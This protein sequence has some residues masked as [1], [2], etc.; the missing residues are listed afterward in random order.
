LGHVRRRHPARSTLRSPEI[1]QNRNFALAND[2]VKFLFVDFDRL[3][4]SR[5]F[6]LAGTA[7]AN[8]GKV[9]GGNAIWLAARGTVANDRHGSILGHDSARMP[10]H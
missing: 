1:D 8:I 7:L 9:L 3:A 2:L 6:R 4:S 5:Q 10:A